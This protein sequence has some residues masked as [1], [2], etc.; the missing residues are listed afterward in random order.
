MEVVIVRRGTTGDDMS[1]SFSGEKGGASGDA[2]PA[3]TSLVYKQGRGGGHDARNA[4]LI[5]PGCIASSHATA[6]LCADA[7]CLP[8]LV[9]VLPIVALPLS[10]LIC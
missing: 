10:L 2:P 9:V 6:S 3:T 4:S 5:C 1:A 8:W 7:S